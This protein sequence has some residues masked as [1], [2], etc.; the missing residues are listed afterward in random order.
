M[1]GR[2]GLDVLAAPAFFGGC[3][4]ARCPLR[5]YLSRP[6]RHGSS[7]TPPPRRRRDA[8]AD[9]CP[10]RHAALPR[11]TERK[12][13]RNLRG[14]ATKISTRAANP[15]IG[16]TSPLPA[17]RMRAAML[18]SAVV[19]TCRGRRR[20]GAIREDVLSLSTDRCG[21]CG[22]VCDRFQPDC[23]RLAPVT[24]MHARKLLRMRRAAG[25]QASRLAR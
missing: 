10:P 1:R 2:L 14:R 12:R 21:G 9:V 15:A 6:P 5:H 23:L 24:P 7:S 3:D 18:V 20:R 8:L 17:V 13:Q 22:G 19:A 11:L 16:W 4:G 25:L